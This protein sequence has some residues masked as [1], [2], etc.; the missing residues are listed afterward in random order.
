MCRFIESIKL[1]DGQFYRLAFHQARVNG[2]FE[3]FFAT[4][5]P[6]DLIELLEL[7]NFPKQGIY[8]C[9][10]VF[11]NKIQLI[12]FVPYIRR[13]TKSMKLVETRIEPTHYKSE[14]RDKINEAIAQKGDCDDIIM[15]NNGFLSDASYSNIALWDGK[16]WCTPTLPLIY[17]TQRAS[18]LE[19]GKIIES[20][21]AKEDLSIYK[22]I[23]LFNAMIEFGELELDCK[24]IF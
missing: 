1:V 7:E 19:S 13:E 21:I 20:S 4:S 2:I 22:R 14:K 18:L 23:R 8:K 9:R 16:N 10:I 12:E 24:Y 6:F 5:R 17:G 11:D 15:L 3:H